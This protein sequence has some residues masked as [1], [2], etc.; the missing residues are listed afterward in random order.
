MLMSKL[1]GVKRAKASNH[2]AKK[3]RRDGKIPAVLYEMNL[4][5]TLLEIGAL[6]LNKQ[7]STSGEHGELI[8]NVDGV[9]RKTLIKEIQRE[10]VDHNIIH[11]DLEEVNVNK[12]IVTDVPLRFV[13]EELVRMSGGILQKEKDSIKVQCA[14]G[15]MPKYITIDFSDLHLGDS[16]KVGNVEVPNG[17]TII[18]D[19]KSVIASISGNNTDR[20]ETEEETET[21]EV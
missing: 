17:I 21:A 18:D 3:L 8:I 6:E 1:I 20:G 11:I 16:M 9:D 7:I 5:N 12:I 14:E 19:A 4:Q 2:E 15:I 13:G 10:P